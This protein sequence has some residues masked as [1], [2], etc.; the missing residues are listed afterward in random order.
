MKRSVFF[1]ALI[2]IIGTVFGQTPTIEAAVNSNTVGT[3]QRFEYEIVTNNN[4]LITPPN[5]DGLTVVAG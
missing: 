1:I 2:S 3:N 5:F 4:C